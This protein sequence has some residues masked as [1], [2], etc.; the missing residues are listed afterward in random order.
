MKTNSLLYSGTVLLEAHLQ[1]K[2]GLVI[3][4]LWSVLALAIFHPRLLTHSYK[5]GPLLQYI[6]ISQEL[7]LSALLQ[8]K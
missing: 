7:E 3:S 8:C 1:M 4:T 5:A 6:T 2:A